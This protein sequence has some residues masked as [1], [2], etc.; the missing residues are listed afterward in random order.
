MA[1]SLL[2]L[3]TNLI[4]FLFVAPGPPSNVSFPDVSFTT[5]RIIWDVPTEP[6]GKILA[7]RLVFPYLTTIAHKKR[8]T[9]LNQ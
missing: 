8:R 5:A 6:N 4:L 9:S 3:T 7:Y 1:V 2:Y